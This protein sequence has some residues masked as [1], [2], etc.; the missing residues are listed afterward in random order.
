M[1][2]KTPHFNFTPDYSENF[3]SNLSGKMKIARQIANN[4][5]EEKPQEYN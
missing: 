1:D 4:H 2:H 5:M 3:V